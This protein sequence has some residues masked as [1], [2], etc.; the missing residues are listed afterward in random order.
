MPLPPPPTHPPPT[1]VLDGVDCILLGAE[2]Y[3]GKYGLETVATVAAICKEA[4]AVFDHS[5]HFEHLTIESEYALAAAEAV[6]AADAQRLRPLREALDAYIV[7]GVRMTVRD[8]CCAAGWTSTGE[9]PRKGVPPSRP[10]PVAQ[11]HARPRWLQC[12]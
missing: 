5:N 7:G 8:F 12:G 1:A 11:N 6:A 10:G 2:T 3:R 9:A 4:E